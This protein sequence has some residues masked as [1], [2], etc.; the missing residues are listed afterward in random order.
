MNNGAESMNSKKPLHPFCNKC[1]W[2][3]GGLD[4]WD[5]KACKCGHYEPPFPPENE[6]VVRPEFW[7][8]ANMGWNVPR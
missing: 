4:S 6:R 8:T 1:G 5:G 2:R 3:K 7:A